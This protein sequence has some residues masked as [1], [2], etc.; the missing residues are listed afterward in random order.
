MKLCDFGLSRKL[1]EDGSHDTKKEPTSSVPLKLRAQTPAMRLSIAGTDEW[2]A[3]EVIVGSK[4]D[5]VA[6][7][8]SYGIVLY[9]I[10]VRQKPKQRYPHEF[11]EFS[12]KEF[13]A[14]APADA[15]KFLTELTIACCAYK[16]SE[17]PVMMSSV[18]KLRS[19]IAHLTDDG[20]ADSPSMLRI[21]SS[22]PPRPSSTSSANAEKKDED[23]SSDGD[24]SPRSKKPL[25]PRKALPPLP[26]VTSDETAAGGGSGTAGRKPPSPRTS[27]RRHM[28]ES[29]ILPKLSSIPSS[30]HK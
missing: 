29:T 1:E 21:V 16:P 3:P 17:R 23:D 9:E 6:D 19:E 2:M 20:N 13:A 18:K 24:L 27:P 14:V 26:P 4:Y 5:H 8:F 12:A 11:F 15:P 7:I 22:P 30:S 25:S 10:I 28:S